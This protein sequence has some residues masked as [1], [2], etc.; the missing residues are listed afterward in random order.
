MFQGAVA[1]VEV[2][3]VAG[4]VEVTEVAGAAGEISSPR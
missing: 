3:E 4:V 1:E 2:T